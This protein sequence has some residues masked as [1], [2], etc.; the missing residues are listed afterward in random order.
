MQKICFLLVVTLTLVGCEVDDGIPKFERMSPAE[1][2]AYNQ[3][4][5]PEQMIVC[6]DEDRSFSR[7]RRRRCGTV[8]SMYGSARQADQLGVLNSA[9]LN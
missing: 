6:S 7:V 1:L 4:R 2:A 8:E 5:S 9:P 3:G